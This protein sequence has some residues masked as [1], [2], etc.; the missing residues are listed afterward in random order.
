[1]TFDELWRLNLNLSRH[2]PYVDSADKQEAVG[3]IADAGKN[4]NGLLLT[5]EDRVFLAEVGIRL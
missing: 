5:A 1:M 4:P 2:L 3:L